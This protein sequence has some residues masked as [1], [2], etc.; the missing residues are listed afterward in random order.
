M[1]I[2][3]AWIIHIFFTKNVRLYNKTFA[4]KR[5]IA[6]NRHFPKKKVLFQV[7]YKTMESANTKRIRIALHYQSYKNLEHISACVYNMQN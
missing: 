1:Y 4:G 7:F 2:V 6:I 3:Y 5:N